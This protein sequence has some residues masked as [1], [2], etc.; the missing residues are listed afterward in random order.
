MSRD[1]PDEYLEYYRKM[2]LIRRFEEKVASMFSDDLVSGTCHLCCGQEACAVGAV[3]ALSETDLIVSN[4]R[5]H[6]HLL[7]RGGDPVRLMAE[8]LGKAEGYCMGKGGTQHLC[9]MDIAFLGT[10][11]VTGGGI[12]IATGAALSSQYRDSN[13]V[14]ACF[15]GDGASN[16]GTFHESLNMASIWKLPV[17]YFCENNLYGMSM[18]ANRSMAV[19]DIAVRS[20]AYDMPGV[21]VDG[22]DVIAVRDAVAAAVDRARSGGGPS[23]VE[24]KTYRYEGHSKSD[25]RVYRTKAEEA[26]WRERDPITNWRAKLVDTGAACDVLGKIEREV[27]VQVENA[28]KY[29]QEASFAEPEEATQGVYA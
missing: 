5:G 29:A 28:V 7:A 16:Q 4:H 23:L 14:V 11:G 9:A 3:S 17:V 18:H 13:E 1:L 10:N 2:V 25:R 12:P 27:V 19:R 26:S 22:M 6:G 15:F 8:L 24:A 20:Q 21:I